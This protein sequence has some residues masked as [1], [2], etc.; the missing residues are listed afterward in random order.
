MKKLDMNT[1]TL[2]QR[3]VIVRYKVM[4]QRNPKK[5][6]RAQQ[7]AAQG[8][9]DIDRKSRILRGQE[10]EVAETRPKQP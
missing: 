2:S 8:R 7:M 3:A 6:A 9:I 1:A 4:Q 5:Y 10:S